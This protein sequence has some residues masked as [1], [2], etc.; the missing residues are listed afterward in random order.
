MIYGSVVVSADRAGARGAA[1]A[2]A[3]RSSPPSICRAAPRL[4]V[5]VLIELLAGVPSVVYG[6]LGILLLRDWIYDAL[7]ALR[8]AERRHAA[9]RRRAA[10]GDDSADRRDA[11]RR[12]AARRARRATP[13]RARARAHARGDDPARRAAAGARAV[14]ARRCCSRSA[15]RSA[16]RSPSSSSSAGRTTTCP[17]RWL[18][19]R[20]LLESGQT[21]TSK[22]GGSETNIAYGDPL[23]WAAIVGLGLI[24]LVLTG[25]AHRAR[26]GLWEEGPMRKAARLRCSRRSPALCALVAVGILVGLVVVIAQRGAPALSWSFFTEQIRLVGAAGGIFWNLIGTADPARHAPSSSARRW[27][28]ALALVERVWLRDAPRA[29][30]AAHACSTR[31]MACPSIVFGIFG[32]IVLRAVVRLGK[33]VARRRH[34]ARAEHAADGH[35]R[36]HR[37]AQ[38]DPGEVRRS[39]RRARAAAARRSSGRCCC[40]RRGAGCITGS[41][42]GLARAAGETAP[43]MFTATIFAGA[44]LPHGDQGQPGALAAVSHL[45]PRAGFVRSRRRREALG[46]R[47]RPARA[48]LSAQPR[49]R[50]RAA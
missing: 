48:G 39:R 2:W 15:A 32:F 8:S 16:R 3:R 46:R 37:A 31:S 44:T 23:H 50:C 33:I 21:L 49:S 10:R 38:G 41:L 30:R 17:T 47:A 11:Q 43:I 24:L 29:A 7:R 18:S 12:R 4:A 35:R 42:L 22:L 5:K 26:H 34:R 13:R 27:P 45:H 25:G 1:R 9:D 36:A 20:P 6:L 40:R 28:S 14:S 19:L